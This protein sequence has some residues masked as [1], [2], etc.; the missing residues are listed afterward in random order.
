MQAGQVLY[1]LQRKVH[2]LG[3]QL[4]GELSDHFI[5]KL[6][7]HRVLFVKSNTSPDGW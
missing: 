3:E 5:E 7:V 4:V 1:V 2:V 6:L